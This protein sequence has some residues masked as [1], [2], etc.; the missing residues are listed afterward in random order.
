[1]IRNKKKMKKTENHLNIDTM[2]WNIIENL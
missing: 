2:Q 1:M